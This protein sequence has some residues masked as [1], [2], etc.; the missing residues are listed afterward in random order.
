M[1]NEIRSKYLDAVSNLSY[2]FLPSSDSSGGGKTLLDTIAPEINT[3]KQVHGK[4]FVWSWE[5]EKQI[6][7]ADGI[8]T[9]KTN[10]PVG[11]YSADCTPILLAGLKED[12]AVAVAAVHAGWRSTALKIGELS[13]RGF[14]EKCR[15][16]E[17]ESVVALIGPCISKEKFEVGEEL[18]DKFPEAKAAGFF[19][20]LREEDGKKKYL[21]DLVAENKRQLKTTA[22]ELQLRLKIDDVALCTFSNLD[23]PSFRRDREKAGRILSHIRFQ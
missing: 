12:R 10:H 1:K 16:L 8:G 22:E 9:I 5:R 6:R 4:E 15:T 11:I 20:F 14:A 13:L 2:G 21:L 3:V 17:A 7:Q 18:L 23:W 19:T